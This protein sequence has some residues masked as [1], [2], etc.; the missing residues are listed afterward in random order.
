MIDSWV[1]GLGGGRG[2]GMEFLLRCKNFLFPLGAL[3]DRSVLMLGKTATL[4]CCVTLD[5]SLSISGP[6]FAHLK[7]ITTVPLATKSQRVCIM[8]WIK[9]HCHHCKQLC[10]EMRSGCSKKHQS[11]TPEGAVYVV[12]LWAVVKF[13][14]LGDPMIQERGPGTTGS[15]NELMFRNTG[16]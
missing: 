15:R 10:K 14:S 1:E 7:K 6:Q 5:K 16:S 4:I 2:R 11:Q 13:A 8:S 12:S 3:C 9:L